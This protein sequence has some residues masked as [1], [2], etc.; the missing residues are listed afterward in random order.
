MNAC[1][2]NDEL[3]CAY[4]DGELDPGESA[5]MAARVAEEPELARRVAALVA[6]KR[7]IA[8]FGAEAAVVPVRV[9]GGPFR[10]RGGLWQKLTGLA[11]ASLAGATLAAALMWPGYRQDTAQMTGAGVVPIRS[12]TLGSFDAIEVFATLHDEWTSADGMAVQAR[13]MPAASTWPDLTSAGLTLVR[14]KGVLGATGILHVGYRGSHGCRLSLFRVAGTDH[15]PAQPVV[16]QEAGL[17]LASWQNDR[18][19]F[20]MLSRGMDRHRFAALAAVLTALTA[21]TSEEHDGMQMAALTGTWQRC[22]G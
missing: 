14:E 13:F 4:V 3:I 5:L 20:V 6:L 18:G 19:R 7:A 22:A 16:R 9:P 1:T 10:T 2:L 17:R 12:G 21:S 15:G 8:N 11:T